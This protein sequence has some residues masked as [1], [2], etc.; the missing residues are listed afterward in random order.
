M[1]RGPGRGTPGSTPFICIVKNKNIPK[2]DSPNKIF[3]DE[4]KQLKEE[5]NRLKQENKR[6]QKDINIMIEYAPGSKKYNQAKE[7]FESLQ[8]N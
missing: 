8:K 2:L 7:H 1:G 5:I 6:L 3:T 4:I